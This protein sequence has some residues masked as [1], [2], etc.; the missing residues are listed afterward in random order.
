M[1]RFSPEYLDRTRR[2]MWADD[3]EA[4]SD[5]ELDSRESVLDVGCGTGELTRVLAEET[6]PETRLLG[7]DADRDLLR[8]A[9]DRNPER[10]ST[11]VGDATRI[12]L[13]DDSVDL[14][15]CQ[16]LLINLPDPRAAVREFARVSSDLVATVEPNNAD[17]GVSSTV[18]REKRLEREAREAYLDGVG[19]NV[20][21][22]DRVR[23]LFR[24]EGFRDVTVR[25]YLH[26]KRVAPPYS[27]RSMEAAVRKASGSGLDE[28]R[29]ELEA[30]LS[31]E[32][33]EDLKGRWRS[34][35]REVIDDM[36]AGEYERVEV[37]PFEVTVGRVPS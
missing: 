17:V 3:R 25:R 2:G 30:A 7:I 18:E 33:Y 4:L 23:E 26:E 20:A 16:A 28:H 29:A 9:R 15:A 36:Q 19:T 34:M 13:R 11:C 35:G 5:L 1:R 12:P 14:L 6:S 27:E 10:V 37:V 24:R 32:A 8:V 21:L 22:G 31:P